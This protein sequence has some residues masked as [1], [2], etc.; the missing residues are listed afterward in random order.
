MRRIETFD[1]WPDLLALKDELSLRELADRFEVTPGAI[2]AAF[3]RTGTARKPAPPGPRALRKRRK[4]AESLPPEAGDS[5]S[6]PR[7]G[8]KD[9]L[10]ENHRHLLG[11]VPDADVAKKA[12]VSVRTVA[13]YRSRNNVPGYTGP[14][15]P[16]AKRRPRTSRI[17]PFQK[18]LGTVPD[19]VV[20]EQAGV[21][22]NAVRNYRVKRGIQAARRR[23][24][25]DGSVAT[26]SVNNAS[27]NN[28]TPI[29]PFNGAQAWRVTIA[30]GT[31]EQERV[32]VADN[33][34]DA[35]TRATQ[36]ANGGRVTSI[37]WVA[38]VL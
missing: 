9:Q 15:R 14:R 36:S 38:E 5:S 8:S 30:N 23:N 11:V 3:K 19:R 28:K 25:D 22:L 27:N 21:S 18:L 16:S 7:P 2:S 24:A 31:G 17:D 33:L 12:G 34:I 6:S 20:A 1:W 26:N 29:G 10:I 32:V 35:A 4:S 37:A 13:S